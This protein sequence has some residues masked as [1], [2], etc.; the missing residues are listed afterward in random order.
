MNTA[1]QDLD[2][3]LDECATLGNAILARLDRLREESPIFWSEPTGPSTGRSSV[4]AYGFLMLASRVM[5]IRA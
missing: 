2:F 4:R 1:L 3:G 5:S